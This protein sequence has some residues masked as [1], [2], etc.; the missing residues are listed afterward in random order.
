MIIKFS[1]SRAR[2]RHLRLGTKNKINKN[3]NKLDFM[4]IKNFYCAKVF[5]CERMKT[6]ATEW[7]K[8][9]ANY[10]FHKGRYLEYREDSQNSTEKKL[11]IT[12]LSHSFLLSS[13][14]VGH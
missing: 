12:S 6:Q 2:Q 1:G 4:K 11:S 14:I 13:D 3:K 5:P 7:E 8:L 9:F 10:R